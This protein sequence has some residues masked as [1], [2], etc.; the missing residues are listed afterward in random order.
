MKT[1]S[2]L[3]AFSALALTANCREEDKGPAPAGTPAAVAPAAHGL[4]WAIGGDWR[5][6]PYV[7]LQLNRPQDELS[8]VL[9]LGLTFKVYFD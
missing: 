6:E 4:D 9:A 8:R 3:L 2:L 5:L 1:R 7:V